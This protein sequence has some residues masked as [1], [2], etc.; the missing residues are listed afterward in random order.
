M[1]FRASQPMDA[2]RVLTR[3]LRSHPD[4]PFSAVKI[5][6]YKSLAFLMIT[7]TK[8]LLS[9]LNRIFKNLLVVALLV[10]AM[11]VNRKNL[12]W[13]RRV[14]RG[15]NRGAGKIIVRLEITCKIALV[16]G[17]SAPQ[18]I[19]IV[20]SNLWQVRVSVEGLHFYNCFR[21]CIWSG[22]CT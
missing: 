20:S 10:E 18:T 21:S 17:T 19:F 8:C 7:L 15:I 22:G 9:E 6:L 4:Y 13:I 14:I 12:I 5:L 3:V 16:C 1:Q 11:K 2:N